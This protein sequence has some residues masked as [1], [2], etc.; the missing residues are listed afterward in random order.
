MSSIESANVA[1]KKVMLMASHVTAKDDEIDDKHH[2]IYQHFTSK[3]KLELG[4]RAAKLGILSTVRYF[5]AKSGEERTLLYLLGR[6]N[7]CANQWR[8][9]EDPSKMNCQVKSEGGHYWI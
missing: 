5:T 4:K 8:S 2:G 6:K 9:D 7:I 3:E 1:V